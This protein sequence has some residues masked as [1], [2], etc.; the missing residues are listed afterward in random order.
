M[1]KY[2]VHLRVILPAVALFIL[3]ANFE[4]AIAGASFGLD[5]C[6]HSVIP[7]LL[8]FFV[9][10]T[11]LS[12]TLT[13]E[14]MGFLAPVRRLCAIPKGQEG[15]FFIGLLCGYPIGAQNI[16]NAYSA[17]RIDQ[18]T[19]RRLLGFC[20]NAGPSFIFGVTSLLFDTWYIPWVLWG[21]QI[22]SAIFVGILIPGKVNKASAPPVP[23]R[24][25]LS[26]ALS[27][28]L[29]AIANVCGWVILFRAAIEILNCTIGCLIP[30]ILSVVLAGILELTNGCFVLHKIVDENLRFVFCSGFLSFGGICVF[31][32]TKSV[33]KELG[34]ASYALGKTLQTSISVF[35]AS[36][37]QMLLFPATGNS[38]LINSI[39]FGSSVMFFLLVFF[40]LGKKEVAFYENF[41]YN[42][43]NAA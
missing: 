25:T 19:A 4:A 17:Q 41:L 3:I 28:S 23:Q 13:Y 43:K 10:S 29:R 36:L 20:S 27:Q 21:I 1:K 6:I 38:P 39:L 22:F 11:L 34:I 37:L 15:I 24:I 35:T 31:M 5:F 42:K 33:T 7:A 32:Q 18:D 2:S 40:C 8:P 16:Y 9:L 26:H 30:E 12:S 14:S